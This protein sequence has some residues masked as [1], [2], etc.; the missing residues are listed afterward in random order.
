MILAEKDLWKCWCETCDLILISKWGLNKYPWVQRG[1]CIWRGKDERGIRSRWQQK[2]EVRE[3]T[4]SSGLNIFAS[5]SPSTDRRIPYIIKIEVSLYIYKKESYVWWGSLVQ[6]IEIE[7]FQGLRTCLQRAGQAP[8]GLLLENFQMFYSSPE[9]SHIQMSKTSLLDW[10]CFSSL[11]SSTLSSDG[12]SQWKGAPPAQSLD[13]GNFPSSGTHSSTLTHTR[14]PSPITWG[15]E[16][17]CG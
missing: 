13:Q 4:F 7:L 15:R 14:T 5:A 2:V 11:P 12:P 1:R 6:V 17:P 9:H 8:I 16:T 10:G 3:R